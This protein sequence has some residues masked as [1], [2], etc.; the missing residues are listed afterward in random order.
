M[1]WS[2]FLF[3]M[4]SNKST[5]SLLDEERCL[6]VFQGNLAVTVKEDG[7]LATSD[8]RQP[9]CQQSRRFSFGKNGQIYQ[10]DSKKC[11]QYVGGKCHMKFLVYI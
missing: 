7:S 9:S 4:A 10:A 8:D 6:R 1:L 11:L 5:S 2:L 3:E